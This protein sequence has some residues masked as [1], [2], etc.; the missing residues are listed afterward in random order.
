MKRFKKVLVGVGAL[1]GGY[2]AVAAVLAVALPLEVPGE[3]LRPRAGDEFGSTFEK[4]DQKI[5]EDRGDKVFAEVTL[6]EGA[7]GPPL[8]YHEGFAEDFEV[9]EGELAL[10]FD[11]EVL[12][13]KAGEKHSIPPG[14]MH[15]PFTPGGRRAVIRGEVPRIFATCLSQLYGTMDESGPGPGMMLQLAMSHT[16]CDTHVAPMPV[17]S[18]MWFL[19][20]PVA[21]LSGYES[22]YPDRAPKRAKPTAVAD[23]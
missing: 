16:Y 19:L 10:E 1:A 13:L 9:V 17:E 11:G 12:T 18:V 22:F 5:L 3:P 4:V 20:N 7:G 21:R 6:H 8:H 15:R 2:L 23:L 14:V